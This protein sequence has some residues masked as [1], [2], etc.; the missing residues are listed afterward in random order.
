ME[1]ELAAT[2]ARRDLHGP[3]VPD[4]RVVPGVANPAR[5]RLRW[6]RDYYRPV[7]RVGSLEPALIQPDVG[8]VIGESPGT[9]EI[10][11]AVTGQL[12]ARMEVARVYQICLHMGRHYRYVVAGCCSASSV[13][14]A[15]I[16]WLLSGLTVRAGC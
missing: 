1:H 3:P 8:I 15:A 11:P 12:R 7:E 2:V 4:H 14:I 16:V 13:P 5:A 10:D 6:E 9:A